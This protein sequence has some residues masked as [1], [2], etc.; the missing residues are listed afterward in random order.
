MRE[1]LR[2]RGQVFLRFDGRQL[3]EN[4]K[5]YTCKYHLL[6]AECCGETHAVCSTTAYFH[7]FMYFITGKV[8]CCLSIRKFSGN[9]LHRRVL[10]YKSHSRYSQRQMPV[11]LFKTLVSSLWNV[12]ADVYHA[13][14]GWHI[15]QVQARKQVVNRHSLS[16]YA[17]KNSVEALRTWGNCGS[18]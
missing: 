2:S 9:V 11:G 6:N 7:W 13:P 15:R 12:T 18:R 4:A 17:C 10:L 3:N 8:Y 1:N 5:T 14:K 16:A